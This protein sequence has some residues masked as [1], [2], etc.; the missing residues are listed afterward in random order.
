MNRLSERI[1]AAWAVL[2][3]PYCWYVCCKAAEPNLEISKAD[4]LTTAIGVLLRQ[5]ENNGVISKSRRDMMESILQDRSVILLSMAVLPATE[6]PVP[7][8]TYDCETEAD[9]NEL[10]EVEIE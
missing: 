8:I 4:I 6:I 5:M 1:K 10:K 3:A 2:T 7:T 9:F